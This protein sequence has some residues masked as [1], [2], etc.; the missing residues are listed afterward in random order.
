M[1]IVVLGANGPS[2]RLLVQ[3][4][5]DRGFEINA[6]TRH[7]EAFPL[8]HDRLHILVGD[9]TDPPTTDAAIVGCDVVISVIG[10]AYT[11]RPV[12]VYSA[13][14]RLV[15]DSMNRHGLSRLLVVTSA[16]VAPESALQGQFFADH[17][18][19]PF[20]RR[21]IGRTVYDDMERMEKIVS[22]TEL[23]WTI[24]RPPGLTSE[25]GTGYKA[26]KIR[27]VG[28]Y[29]ARSDLAAFLL[30]QIESDQF[31]KQIAAVSSP[32]IRVSALKTI[33][34]EVLKG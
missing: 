5:L 8:R 23:D 21:V 17:F 30:D 24:V 11:R 4:A 25:P 9:A 29:C 6:L 12:T 13:T 14:A 7:P 10:A 33:R 1:R 15:V 18:L 3:Q 32:D 27:V 22:A 16:E 31:L 34:T 2:G 26:A 20:L 19:Y 28:R